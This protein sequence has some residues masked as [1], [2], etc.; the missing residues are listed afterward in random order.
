M[1]AALLAQ[2]PRALTF[3]VSAPD[4]PTVRQ[5]LAGGRRTAMADRVRT[6]FRGPDLVLRNPEVT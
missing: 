3:D 6:T 1:L 4:A 5:A 2:H